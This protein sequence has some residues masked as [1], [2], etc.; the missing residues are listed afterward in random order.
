MNTI[1]GINALER[2]QLELR[3]TMAKSDEHAL[4]CAKSGLDF[5]ETYPDDW[6]A[7]EAARQE[8]NENEKALAGLYDLRK[9]EEEEE[10]DDFDM[11]GEEYGGGSERR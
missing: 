3:A 5:R 11:N 9:A 6:T 1:E 2:R 8:Y 4:K 10:L 7:Y